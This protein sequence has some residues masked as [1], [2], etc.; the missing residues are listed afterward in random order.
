MA[1]E[2]T[3]VLVKPDG[4]QRHLVGKIIS[5]FEDAGLKIVG[6]KMI[7]VD[8]KF[9][10]KHYRREDIAE[11]H[12]EKIWRNLIE[13]IIE[14]PVVAMVLEGTEA[15]EVVRKI[16][17]ST[18]PKTA[19]PGTIRGDF[20]HH[21]YSH[22]DSTGKAVRNVVHASANKEDAKIEIGV[23]FSNKDEVHSYKTVQDIFMY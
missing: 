22:A 19:M 10:E 1:T 16:V 23:W 4:V 20:S 6:M 18:E 17:G 9:A 13:L 2:R 8:G 12:G 15:I 7:W 3:L 11:R 14:G 5:R 21:T